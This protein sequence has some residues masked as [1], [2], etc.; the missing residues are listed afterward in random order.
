MHWARAVT[1]LR[2]RGTPGVLVTVTAVRGHAPRD[3]GA[4]MVVSAEQTWGS[5]GGGNVEADAVE[6]ARAM[7]AAADTQASTLTNRLSDKAHQAHGR[8]CCGGEVTITLEPLPAPPTPI[9]RL[10]PRG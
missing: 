8:Q 2:D 3:V 7:L 4:R 5:V 1:H 9:A 10:K 6:R